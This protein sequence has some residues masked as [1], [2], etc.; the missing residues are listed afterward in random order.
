MHIGRS[1]YYPGR[2]AVLRPSPATVRVIEY[3]DDRG[4]VIDGETGEILRTVP[5]TG[6]I[7]P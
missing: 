1:D 6:D 7:E 4:R 5:R 3:L 2:Y